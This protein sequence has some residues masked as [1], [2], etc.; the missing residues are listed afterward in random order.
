MPRGRHHVY[1]HCSLSPHSHRVFA[2]P[3]QHRIPTDPEAW[4][5]GK[6]Q[7]ENK[8]MTD[9]TTWPRFPFKPELTLNTK[10]KGMVF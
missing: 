4:E 9:G 10:R 1:S 5:F 6:T 7:S 3:P 2:I 8:P